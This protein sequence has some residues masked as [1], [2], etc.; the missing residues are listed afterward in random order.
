MDALNDDRGQALVIAVLVLA[1]AAVAIA[2]LRIAQERIV[3][4]AR[5]RRAGEAAVEA[6][7]AV[8]ADAYAA[9]ER[10]AAP[11]VP[12][13]AAVVAALS[14]ARVREAAREAADSLSLLNGGAAV[15]EPSVICANGNVSVTLTVAERRYRAGFSAPLCSPH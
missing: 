5:E 9:E 1:I 8:F 15:D 10:V 4:T 11:G 3:A 13:T 12:R 7:T 6:A 14:A 2:G